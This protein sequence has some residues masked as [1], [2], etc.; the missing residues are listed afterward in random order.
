MGTKPRS[1][2][3]N[4]ESWDEINK[5]GYDDLIEKK[6]F[7]FIEDKINALLKHP[8]T[9]RSIVDNF[10]ANSVNVT[11]NIRD[12]M[13]N[14]P[15]KRV[16]DDHE[17]FPGKLDHTT[18]LAIRIGKKLHAQDKNYEQLAGK[19]K[20]NMF[21][22]SPYGAIPASLNNMIAIQAAYGNSSKTRTSFPNSDDI[23]CR[24]FGKEV[25]RSEKKFFFS[26][27][28]FRRWW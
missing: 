8:V 3:L 15:G 13:Q 10:L 19:L 7:M 20:D 17:K 6:I 1:I 2:G 11:F 18:C 21:S 5:K 25:Y 4:Y 9:P 24:I 14:N 12:F 28:F 23:W 26:H 27:F 16:A 22:E